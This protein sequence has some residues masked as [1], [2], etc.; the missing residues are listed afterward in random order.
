MCAGACPIDSKCTACRWCECAWEWL[1]LAAFVCLPPLFPCSHGRESSEYSYRLKY[2]GLRG[3]LGER[4]IDVQHRKD[5]DPERPVIYAVLVSLSRYLLRRHVVRVAY[6][7]VCLEGGWDGVQRAYRSKVGEGRSPQGRI[8]INKKRAKGVM[9]SALFSEQT[10]LNIPKRCGSK[11]RHAIR[12]LQGVHSTRTE[13][14]GGQRMTT[15]WNPNLLKL[16]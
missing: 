4:R 16:L 6:H 13:C 8:A 7:S 5:K 3:V 15:L 2:L 9:P 1:T 14:V 10:G 12:R 11:S